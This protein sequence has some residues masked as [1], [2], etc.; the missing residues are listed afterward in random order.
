MMILELL[1][2]YICLLPISRRKFVVFWNSFL[3][4]KRY[5]ERKFHNVLCLML[6]PRFNIF[7]LVSSFIGCEEGV[8]IVDECER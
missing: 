1:L 5:E 7:H 6:N 4:K 8:N 3:L 2:S